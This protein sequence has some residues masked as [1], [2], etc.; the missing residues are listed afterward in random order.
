M[1]RLLPVVLPRGMARAEAFRGAVGRLLRERVD[2]W[3]SDGR[4]FAADELRELLPLA[5]LTMFKAGLTAEIPQACRSRLPR[6][7]AP[8]P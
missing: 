2:F 5:T 1:R 8:E 6:A 3:L 7:L 4:R